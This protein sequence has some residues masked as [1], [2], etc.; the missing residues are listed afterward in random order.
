MKRIL[1]KL[2]GMSKKKLI[3][4]RDNIARGEGSVTEKATIIIAIDARL[5]QKKDDSLLVVES[6]LRASS[7]FHPIA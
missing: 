6:E 3:A 4:L 2:P 1:E 5:E 7:A